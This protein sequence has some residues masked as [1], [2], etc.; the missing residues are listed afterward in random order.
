LGD[1]HRQLLGI[2]ER[3]Q[4]FPAPSVNQ[5]T[6]LPETLFQDWRR[7]DQIPAWKTDVTAIEDKFSPSHFCHFTTC[8]AECTL[9]PPFSGR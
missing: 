4:R 3:H 7:F 6:N 5:Q 2:E 8:N 9:G 1:V